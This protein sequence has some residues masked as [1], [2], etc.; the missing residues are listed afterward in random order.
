M[1]APTRRELSALAAAVLAKLPEG[2][3][4]DINEE[5]IKIFGY[6][7]SDALGKTSLEL[8]MYPN[9]EERK[10]SADAVSAQGFARSSEM[11]LRTKAGELRDFLVSSD[12]PG[13]HRARKR[14]IIRKP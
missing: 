4:T 3:F 10:R 8:G 5:F 14:R 9:P 6:T 2:V 12:L 7:R 11:Q 13:R 1:P